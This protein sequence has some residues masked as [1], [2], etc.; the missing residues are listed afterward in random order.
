MKNITVILNGESMRM[1]EG[2]IDYEDL[3]SLAGLR[4]NPSMTWHQ[5]GGAGGILSPGRWVEV[6]AGMVFN[7]VHTG[8][9]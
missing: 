8:N 5:R 3:V 7:V 2:R 1:P 6:R 4:G 9:A